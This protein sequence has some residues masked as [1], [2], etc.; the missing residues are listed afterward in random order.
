MSRKALAP[1]DRRILLLAGWVL[2]PALLLGLVIQPYRVALESAKDRLEEE[3]WRLQRELSALAKVGEYAT[4]LED[5][6]GRLNRHGPRLFGGPDGVTATSALAGYVT[7]RA[8]SSQVL[9]QRIQSRHAEADADETALTLAVDVRAIGDLEGVIRLIHALEEGEKLVLVERLALERIG[10]S[11][12]SP[13]EASV[14]VAATF[15]AF[16]LLQSGVEVGW[17]DLDREGVP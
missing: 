4:L 15:T 10:R 9:V 11:G 14:S 7:E 3:R 1:R 5:A 13:Y 2:V 16:A 12:E 8:R 6:E 17:G